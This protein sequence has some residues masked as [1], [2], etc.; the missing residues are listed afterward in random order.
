[1]NSRRDFLTKALG[2]GAVATAYSSNANN[3]S[4]NVPALPS[5]KGRKV[6]FTFGGWDGHEPQKYIDYLVPWLKGEGADVTTSPNLEPYAN[7]DLMNTIDLVLQIY[8]MSTITKEQ[9]KGLV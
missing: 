7:K 5:L 3:K 9:E 1:M 8:T 4:T 6:L 2:V